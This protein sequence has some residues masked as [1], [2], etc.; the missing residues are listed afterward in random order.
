MCKIGKDIED[1]A[2]NWMYPNDEGYFCR[3]CLRCAKKLERKK[4]EK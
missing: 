2:D 4:Y 3:V 1:L